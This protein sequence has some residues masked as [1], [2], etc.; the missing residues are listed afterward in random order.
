MNYQELKAKD[1]ENDKIKSN[2]PPKT[3]IDKLDNFPQKLHQ[4][5]D[6]FPLK[7]LKKLRYLVDVSRLKIK[8]NLDIIRKV[9]YPSQDVYM[10]LASPSEYKR[11]FP[12]DKEPWTVKW[13][14][15]CLRPGEVMFDIGANVGGYSLIAAK[16]TE[17]KAKIFAFEP[18]F[19]TFSN[20]CYNIVLNN[21]QEAIV[22]FQ[23]ALSDQTALVDFNYSDLEPGSAL[24][25]LGEPIYFT[26]DKLKSAYRQPILS[27]RIDDLITQFNLP[28]P[29]HIKLDVDGTEL[30]VLYGARQTI[31]DNKVRSLMVEL[32]E[33]E[34]KSDEKV[35][36][37]LQANGFYL[38]ER[39]IR[40]NDKHQRNPYSFCIF[41]RDIN[42]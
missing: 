1:I 16:L 12:C 10:R 17:G 21:C 23:I 36:V 14:E 42:Q 18:S 20:L 13:L 33:D 19:S 34:K 31:S 38:K 3:I 29:N 40:F 22:P 25:I 4:R 11:I 35:V 30:E 37:F 6:N 24:H 39:Y 26:G 41:C 8:K 28:I 15:T 27:Y 7:V 32:S 5:L 9:D 2:S